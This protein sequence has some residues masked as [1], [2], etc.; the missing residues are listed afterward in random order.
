MTSSMKIDHQ[1]YE[2]RKHG[3]LIF[4]IYANEANLPLWILS[5]WFKAPTQHTHHHKD[6]K[7]IEI[8]SS[9]DLAFQSREQMW[10]GTL[11]V[12]LVPSFAYHIIS[13]WRR[14]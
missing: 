5:G 1:T 8:T 9:L 6:T 7:K 3:K 13:R 14:P 4:Q 12:K 11:V 10:K 2:K